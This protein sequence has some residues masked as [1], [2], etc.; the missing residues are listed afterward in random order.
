M[1]VIPDDTRSIAIKRFN[2]PVTI[3]DDCPFCKRE[4][5]TRFD[6]DDYVSYPSITEPTPVY[7]YCAPCRLEW[8]RHIRILFSV[9][10][11]A[12]PPIVLGDEG[13]E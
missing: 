5:R 4:C 12:E 9:H 6:G 7:L 2:L 8:K 11:V 10:A 13:E 3:V 1:K